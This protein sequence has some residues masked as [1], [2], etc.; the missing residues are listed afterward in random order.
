MLLKKIL[1]HVAAIGI[2]LLLSIIYFHPQLNGEVIPQGDNIQYLGM[3]RE[4]A[5]FKEKTG[6]TTLWTNSMFGGMPTYQ[7]N[8]NRQGNLIQ[9]LD[10]VLR[11]GFQ[12]PI[13]YFFVAQLAFYVLLI[14]LG[15]NPW[16]GII[17]GISFGFT[18]NSLVLFEAGHNTQV[19]AIAYLPVL[20]AGI[21]LAY[22]KNYLWG[23]II[24]ATGVG[25]N[26]YANHVQMTYYLLLTLIIYGIARLIYDIRNN[27]ILHFGKATGI[28]VV[29]GLLGLGSS[30]V[31]LLTTY[32]YSQQTMRGEPILEPESTGTT[33]SISSSATKGLSWDYAMQWSNG[34][35]DVLA[36]FIPG[37]TGGGSSEPVSDRMAVAKNPQWQQIINQ[38]FG[39]KAPLYWGALPFTSGPIYFGAI[40]VFL[41]LMG[42]WLVPGPTKWWLALGTLLTLLLSMGKNLE[43]FNEFFFNYVPLYNKFRTPNSVLSIASILI[44]LL[45]FL[46]LSRIINGEVDKKEALQGLYIGGG[47]ASAIALFFILIGPSMYDFSSPSDANLQQAGIDLQPLLDS[48]KS[49][50][51]SDALRSLALVLLSGGLIWAYIQNKLQEMIV[52]AGIG[53]L[54]LFDTWTVGKRYVSTDDFVPKSRFEANFQPRPVDEQILAQEKNRGTYRV[55]DLSV[56]P[57]QSTTTSYYHNS[58]GGYHAAKLQRIQDVIDRYLS[59]QINMKVVNMFNIRYFIQPPQQQG[60]QA[61]VEGNNSA[62]GTVWLVSSIRSVPTAN[63]EI[64]ALAEFEP[65]RE[66]VVHQEFSSY[67][68]GLNPSG[69]GTIGMTAYKPNHLTYQSQT[70]DEQFAVFS[71][72]WYGP[73]KGWQAYIDGAPV[74]HIRVNYLLRGLKIPAGDHTIEF[75]FEPQTFYTGRTISVLSSSLILLT[76]LGFVGYQGYNW[77]NHLPQEEERREEKPNTQKPIVRRTQSR[78][79]GKGKKP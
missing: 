39:G 68:S 15:V 3:A 29:A 17:G 74:E 49:L 79:P 73:N 2:F 9:Y 31:N 67:V 56:N 5:E 11:L 42:L 43:A 60:Q 30:A 53:V 75:K 32:E 55:M 12:R 50:M 7:I 58:I 46:G 69:I 8:T 24:F 54:V 21:L 65:A 77:Y 78:K 25:L 45:G 47:I 70:D 37:V 59:G 72:I 40:A 10:S 35:R 76:F 18:T 52:F 23:G 63:A 64:A 36:G 1:P 34:T 38:Y 27:D 61:F 13:G 57:F 33:A 71:E 48:R 4:A 66:A 19:L 41:F 14:S 62:L 26:T 6:E 20:I 44:P 28:L 51:R 16:L 22:R